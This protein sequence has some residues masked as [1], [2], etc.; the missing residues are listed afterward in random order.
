MKRLIVF[1]LSVIL[2]LFLIDNA[3]AEDTN[4]KL[5]VIKVVDAQTIAA[6]GTYTSAPIS[7]AV[8]VGVYSLQ[9]AVSGSGTA[10]FEYNLTNDY[11]SYIEPSTAVDIA[12]GITATSGPGSDGKD[13]VSF[14]PLPAASMKI[15]VTETGAA[16]TTTVSAWLATQ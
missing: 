6:A 16:N 7:L 14:S 12:S 3:N 13:I 11:S 2:G 15:V 10:K 5:K 8:D 9:F 1:V 4:K